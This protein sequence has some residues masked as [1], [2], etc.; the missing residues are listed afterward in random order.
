MGDPLPVSLKQGRIL[1]VYVPLIKPLSQ[2]LFNFPV[3]QL[4][5]AAFPQQKKPAWC[6]LFLLN[7]M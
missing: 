3:Y 4:R 5:P 6:G 2:G 7:V 1:G